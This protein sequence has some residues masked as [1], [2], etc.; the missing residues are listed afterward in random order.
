MDLA[1]T[2]MDTQVIVNDDA[3]KSMNNL[4]KLTDHIVDR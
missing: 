3:E 4:L 2:D 1:A